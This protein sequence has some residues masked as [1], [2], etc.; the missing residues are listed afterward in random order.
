MCCN[1]GY[2]RLQ[3]YPSY[4]AQT[5]SA[6][7]KEIVYAQYLAQRGVPRTLPVVAL[8]LAW[9]AVKEPT[10]EAVALA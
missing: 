4:L 6:A 3:R 1:H 8:G 5:G 2:R 10:A 9:R 7:H